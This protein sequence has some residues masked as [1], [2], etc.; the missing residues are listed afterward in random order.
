[1]ARRGSHRARN[2]LHQHLG[3]SRVCLWRQEPVPART[4]TRERIGRAQLSRERV[5]HMSCQAG[6][7]ARGFGIMQALEVDQLDKQH[8]E[9]QS[10]LLAAL[11]P[12]PDRADPG[13]GSL[14]T[15]TYVSDLD[16]RS[17]LARRIAFARPCSS[18]RAVSRPRALKRG[19]GR[20]AREFGRRRS[21]RL[22]LRW[23]QFV[24]EHSRG[25]RRL[26]LWRLAR[27]CELLLLRGWLAVCHRSCDVRRRAARRE[28]LP[29]LEW[30]AQ[31]A[32][33]ARP[34]PR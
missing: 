27:R 16:L 5:L 14:L 19:R 26:G 11:Q 24:D 10:I 31:D 3:A 7:L 21:G 9:R 18:D 33:V 13:G 32:C 15:S 12:A 8:R 25:G 22:E 34:R 2:S 6:H 17:H 28:W 1:M 20:R 4:L 23:S 30:L 29:R